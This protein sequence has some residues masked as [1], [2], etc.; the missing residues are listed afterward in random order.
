MANSAITISMVDGLVGNDYSTCLAQGLSSV[1]VKILLV[2][3]ENRKISLLDDNIIVYHW[4]PTKDKTK[5]NVNKFFYYFKYLFKLFSLINK[6]KLRIIHYQFFRRKEDILLLLLLKLT[7]TKIVYTAH[8]VLPH[9]RTRIDFYL[10]KLVYLVVNEIIVHSESIKN[11][12]IYTFKI[13][14]KKINV[15]HHGNFDIYL[16][17]KDISKSEARIKLNLIEND[18]IILFFGYIR[19]YKGLDI[20]L[21]AFSIATQKNPRL[22][23]IIAGSPAS[24]ELKEKY[25]Q[26]IESHNFKG[27]IICEFSFI[28]SENIAIYFKASDLVVLPYREIDHSGIVHLSYSFARPIL[29][30]NVGDFSEIIEENKTGFLVEKDDYENFARVILTAFYDKKLLSKMG[31]Y[32]K[33]LSNTKFSWNVIGKMTAN[34]YHKILSE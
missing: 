3:P 9:E 19:E 34:L 20:L 14:H 2:V 6:N 16:P 26:M 25:T 18:D 8:N 1:G 30:T 33:E 32:A 17:Q 11:K 7:G 21:K 5:S 24:L 31:L 4:L 29:A 15:I 23:L 10:Y 28:P 12:L 22:K 13:S 27:R